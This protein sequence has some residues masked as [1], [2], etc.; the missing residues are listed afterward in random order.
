MLGL[1]L[2]RLESLKDMITGPVASTRKQVTRRKYKIIF[3]TF[4]FQTPA[5][6]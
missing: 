3:T 1:P 6:A 5:H 2:S 4:A